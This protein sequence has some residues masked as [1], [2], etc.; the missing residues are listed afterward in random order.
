MIE[1]GTAL[2]HRFLTR[3]SVRGRF[4]VTLPTA[5][6]ALKLVDRSCLRAS[7]NVERDSLMRVAT[8]V[9]HLEIAIA[10]IQRVAETGD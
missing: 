3:S 5:H 6:V 2:L 9:L 1:Q 8:E 7:H 10:G 4:V